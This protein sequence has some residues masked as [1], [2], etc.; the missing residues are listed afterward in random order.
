MNNKKQHKKARKLELRVLSGAFS[1][2]ETTSTQ[3]RVRHLV[4]IGGGD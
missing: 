2:N 4:S 1:E 3:R